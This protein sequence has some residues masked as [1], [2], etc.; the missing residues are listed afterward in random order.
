[1]VKNFIIAD[2]IVAVMILGVNFLL[3]NIEFNDESSESEDARVTVS[4]LNPALDSI[5]ALILVLSA[6]F[7][8]RSLR[9]TTGK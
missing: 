1:M 5:T 3:R 9:N 8:G 2:I 4:F 6:V 7:L